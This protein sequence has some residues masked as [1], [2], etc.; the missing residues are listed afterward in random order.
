MPSWHAA[1]CPEGSILQPYSYRAS[2]SRASSLQETLEEAKEQWKGSALLGLVYSTQPRGLAQKRAGEEGG[3]SPR[4]QTCECQESSGSKG[5]RPRWQRSG[6]VGLPGAG[7]EP[8]R[9]RHYWRP[10][11]PPLPE[12]TGLPNCS[13]AVRKAWTGSPAAGTAKEECVWLKRRGQLRPPAAWPGGGPWDR[14]SAGWWRALPARSCWCP[15][16]VVQAEGIA[17]TMSTRPEPPAA[18]E[19]QLPTPGSSRG[20]GWLSAWHRDDTRSIWHIVCASHG[21]QGC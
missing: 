19:N 1:P 20:L 11:T 6:P 2:D 5:S 8:T 16:A 9:V 12:R 10:S 4:Q 17:A 7:R 15:A 3:E 21:P 18:R 14:R 13:S